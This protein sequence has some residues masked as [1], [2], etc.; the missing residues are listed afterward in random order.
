MRGVIKRYQRLKIN[1]ELGRNRSRIAAHRTADPD[2][3]AGRERLY[4]RHYEL[5]EQREALS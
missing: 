5:I 3:F 2:G 1:R 4:I